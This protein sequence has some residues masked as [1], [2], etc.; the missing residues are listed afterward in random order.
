[1]N[2]NKKCVQSVENPPKNPFIFSKKSVT[3]IA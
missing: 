2:N 3:T 1:M